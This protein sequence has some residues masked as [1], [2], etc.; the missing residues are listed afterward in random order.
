[1]KHTK[2]QLPRQE[3]GA[4]INE[5]IDRSPSYFSYFGSRFFGNDEGGVSSDVDIYERSI[6]SN[7]RHFNS[8]D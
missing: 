5:T 3:E 8:V 2:K 7:V 4:T 1:M 6:S